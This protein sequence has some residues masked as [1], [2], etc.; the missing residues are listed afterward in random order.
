MYFTLTE[1]VELEGNCSAGS[2]FWMIDE[3]IGKP[4]D[5]TVNSATNAKNGRDC[6]AVSGVLVQTSS[7]FTRLIQRP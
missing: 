7:G 6:S 4:A 1:S 3:K 5:P 2:F